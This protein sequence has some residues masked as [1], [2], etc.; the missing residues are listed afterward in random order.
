MNAK[1]KGIASESDREKG[2]AIERE[3]AIVLPLAAANRSRDRGIGAVRV[4]K[5]SG[6]VPSMKETNGNSNRMPRDVG[7]RGEVGAGD[8]VVA[9]YEFNINN[10]V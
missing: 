4:K 2:I 7:S 5:R 3:I 1:E 8:R 10:F 9:G 6:E